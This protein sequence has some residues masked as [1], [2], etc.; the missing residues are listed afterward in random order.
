[1]V[2]QF[3]SERDICDNNEQM[4]LHQ[5]SFLSTDRWEAKHAQN[6]KMCIE[7]K[8]IRR[9]VQ[10]ELDGQRSYYWNTLHMKRLS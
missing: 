1:M 5:L 7:N 4:E 8:N 2:E 3:W 9:N 10:N 6:L